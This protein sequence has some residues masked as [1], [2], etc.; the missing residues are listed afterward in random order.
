MVYEVLLGELKEKPR[1]FINVSSVV[2]PAVPASSCMK[3]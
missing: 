2:P 1:G 3:F